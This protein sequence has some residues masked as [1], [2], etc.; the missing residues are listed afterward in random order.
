MPGQSPDQKTA[1]PPKSKR[2]LLLGLTAFACIIALSFVQLK[3][4]SADSVTFLILFYFNFIVLLLALVMVLRNGLRLLMERRRGVLGARLRAKLTLAFIALSLLPTLLL[5]IIA[6]NFVRIS[7]DYWFQSQVGDAMENAMALGQAYY[8]DADTKLRSSAETLAATIRDGNILQG[9][10]N[11]DTFV[12]KQIQERD[13]AFAAILTDTLDERAV[14]GSTEWRGIWREIKDR[15]DPGTL[16]QTPYWSMPWAGQ[17]VDLLFCVTPL[18]GGLKGYLAAGRGLDHGILLHLARIKSGVEEYA[19]MKSLSDP[20]LAMLYGMLGVISLIIILAAMWF[21]FRVAGQ[22]TEPI[23]ALITGT[24]RIAEGD[25]GVRLDAPGPPGS[26][27]GP[28]REDRGDEIDYLVNSF[29]TMAEDLE[30][31]RQG[32]TEANLR[33]ENQNRALGERGRYIETVLDNITAAVI[34]LDGEGRITTVNKAAESVF[35]LTG[36]SV[37]GLTPAE[38]A[39]VADQAAAREVL[40]DIAAHAD[41]PASGFLEIASKSGVLKLVRNIVALTADNGERGGGV[42]A[43]YED[44]TELEKN[45]RAEAWR[46]VAR[47]IAHEIKN[48]LTPIKLSAQ[49]LK[50]KYNQVVND[51]AFGECTDLI[52]AQTE[53]LRQMVSEFSAYAKLPEVHLLLGELTPVVAEALALFRLSHSRVAWN[54]TVARDLPLARFDPAAMGQVAVN[55]LANA[56]EALEDTPNPRVDIGLSHEPGIG[57]IRLEIADNGPGF[58]PA[59]LSRLFEPYFSRKKSGTGLGLTIVKSI[60]NDHGGVVRARSGENG[61]AVF[62]VEIPAA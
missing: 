59:E 45:Q 46:E 4:L 5:G 49:R 8:A 33:L 62:T 29:N 60:V 44:V 17:G 14:A 51:P 53:H 35:G 9:G 21:G 28:G 1:K 22:L 6:A 24:R 58:K 42:V 3:F 11:L 16:Y 37:M 50:R 36:R 52:V 30:K 34:S 56:A 38:A 18:G 41:L 7:F 2:D 10:V 12:A 31:G 15:F 57:Q 54:F 23:M 43:V 19:G 48:P 55:L 25:L 39:G 32:V 47:R 27:D 40:A 20:V 26:A 61:G 13:L